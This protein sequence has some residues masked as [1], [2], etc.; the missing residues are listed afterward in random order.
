[1]VDEIKVPNRQINNVWGKLTDYDVIK[2]ENKDRVEPSI[3]RSDLTEKLREAYFQLNSTSLSGVKGKVVTLKDMLSDSRRA[4]ESGDSNEIKKSLTQHVHVEA[5]LG[6]ENT[7]H[8]RLSDQFAMNA[9]RE[10]VC[11]KTTPANDQEAMASPD[12]EDHWKP[13]QKA[14]FD[15]LMRMKTFEPVLR[16]EMERMG[17]KPKKLKN[18]RK[19]K[20]NRDGKIEKYK[21][22]QVVQGFSLIPDMEFFENYSSVLAPTNTR[23]LM[24][25]S[26]QTGEKLSSADVGNAF[27]EADLPDDEVIFVEQHPETE[28]EGY[29]RDKYVLRLRKCLYGL[30]QAG[31]GY[32]RDYTKL[33]LSEGFTQTSAENC[34]F[35]K[36][37]PIHGR[38]IV[39]SYVDDLICLTGSDYLR[40]Q[41][42]ASLK[43]RFAKVTY[44]DELDYILGIRVDKGTDANG[45]RYIELNHGVAIEK[46]AKTVQVTEHTGFVKSPMDH[47]KKFRK[48]VDGEDDDSSYKPCYEYASVLGGMLYLANLSRPDLV[49]AT[50]RLSRY[51]SNPSHEHY[52]ALTKLVTFA[53]QTR[54]RCLRYTQTPDDVDCDPFRLFAASDSSYADCIDT[55]RSTIG[56]CLWMG[57]KCSGLIDWKSTLPKTAASSST[58]AELQAAHECTKDII[59]NRVLLHDLGYKQIG[60]TRM[61][62]D[63]NACMSQI[64]AVAGVIKARG[65]IV[66]LRKIQETVHLGIMHT[67]R[68]D[69]K[70]NIADMF[71]K[72]LPVLTFWRLTTL[73]MGDQGSK[74]KYAEVRDLALAQEFNGGSVKQL[75]DQLRE[76]AKRAKLKARAEQESDRAR[77]RESRR[78]Q[79]AA[80]ASALDIAK[81]LMTQDKGAGTV[82]TDTDQAARR[83]IMMHDDVNVTPKVLPSQQNI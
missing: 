32:Q 66:M 35:V 28:L 55:G 52:R 47:S 34:M 8:K 78:L 17:R 51:I 31:R 53:Y 4:N 76:A 37:D 27:V 77:E 58:E 39:G 15:A 12:W 68:I 54:E 5:V 72:P 33:M 50:N 75:N 44:D 80:L 67:Q 79:I 18:V 65:Y 21:T 3:T 13:S 30:P 46:I 38:I 19:I 43:K 16:T 42:R 14:E 1:M 62:I 63:N 23:M 59:Y 49:T 26:A 24:Y 25:L 22:R 69:T 6:D 40:D 82:Q 29:P 56:R 2:H 64:N 41:W 48:K 9:M 20:V 7:V 60:S 73:A 70:D 83:V 74:K 11:G 45:M 81:G 36:H 61:M 71:T 57:K 10:I